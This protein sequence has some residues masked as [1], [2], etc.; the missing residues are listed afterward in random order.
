MTNEDLKRFFKS[1]QNENKKYGFARYDKNG[2]LIDESPEQPLIHGIQSGIVHSVSYNTS[3]G[4]TFDYENSVFELSEA[5]DATQSIAMML[6]IPIKPG[7]G[8]AID[9]AEDGKHLEFSIDTSTITGF[10]TD[11]DLADELQS[12]V[13]TVELSNQLS[14]YITDDALTT[15][16]ANYIPASQKAQ[17][18]GV[19]SLDATGKIPIAQLPSQ[20]ATF[21]IQPSSAE[22][23]ESIAA[24]SYIIQTFETLTSQNIIITSIQPSVEGLFVSQPYYDGTNWKVVIQNL[25]TNAVS[26]ATLLVSFINI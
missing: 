20:A 21:S 4:A 2:N 18:N 19:A 16:L 13:T 11:E 3:D 26:D 7:T 15:E 10:I 22:V 24:N 17:A 5:D 12:Y 1:Y 9:V 25:T 6:N 8:V 14:T 23:V